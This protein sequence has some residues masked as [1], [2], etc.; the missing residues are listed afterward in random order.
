MVSDGRPPA[1]LPT[2]TV[3]LEEGFDDP[4]LVSWFRSA[5][6]GTTLAVANS[7]LKL[8]VAGPSNGPAYVGLTSIDS[9]VGQGLSASITV[10]AALSGEPGPQVLFQVVGSTAGDLAFFQLQDDYVLTCQV[11]Q[12]FMKTGSV[13]LTYDAT[14]HHRWRLREAGGRFYFESISDDGAVH[15]LYD[16][17]VPFAIDQVQINVLLGVYQAV[18]TSVSA[19]YDTVLLEQAAAP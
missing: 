13:D 17:P 6:A 12:A 5:G 4:A 10:D 15:P 8:A 3:I 1:D 14:V 11:E 9:F 7:Q 18:T 2:S 19:V 16:T